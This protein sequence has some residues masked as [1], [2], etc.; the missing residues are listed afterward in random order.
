MNEVEMQVFAVYLVEYPD[1]GSTHIV[2]TGQT[3]AIAQMR[4]D[5]GDDDH[6]DEYAAVRVYGPASEVACKAWTQGW[7]EGYE[8][9]EKA[10]EGQG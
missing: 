9:A 5:V 2:A 7:G 3:E 8:A 4:K 10:K 6:D 1:E